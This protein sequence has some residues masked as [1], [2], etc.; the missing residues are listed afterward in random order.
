MTLSE[1][2]K[3]IQHSVPPG[4]LSI[5][6]QALWFDAKGNWDKAHQLAQEDETSEGS[7]IHAYLHRKEGDQGNASYWYHR[8]KKPVCTN[9]LSEEWEEIAAVLL[10]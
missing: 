6:L 5:L 4:D 8:A 1:F 2:K 9:S 7:W 3:S 10:R